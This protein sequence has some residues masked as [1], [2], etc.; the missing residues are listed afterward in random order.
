MRVTLWVIAMCLNCMGLPAAADAAT[1]LTTNIAAQQLAP[2]LQALTRD[3][4]VQVVYRSELVIDRWTDG[5]SGNLTFEE[6]L[7]QLLNASGLTYRYLGERAITIVPTS[8]GNVPSTS[9][10]ATSVHSGGGEKGSLP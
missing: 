6:A 8:P 9:K 10:L 3:H 4:G 5:A 2:A 1:R 7:M